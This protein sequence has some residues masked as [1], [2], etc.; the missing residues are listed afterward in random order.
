MILVALLAFALANRIN[1]EKEMRLSAQN[2]VLL[3]E[4]LARQS[5]TE[6]LKAQTD[7]NNQLEE[8]VEEIAKLS[9]Q[10]GLEMMEKKDPAHL[11]A[12]EKMRELM[13]DPAKMNQWF[14]SKRKEF[15]EALF[16]KF[17]NF[18]NGK[19]KNKK[20]IKGRKAK[21]NALFERRGFIGRA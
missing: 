17:I 19:S 21:R 2:K 6:L 5:Q 1:R 4:K 3:S 10:H 14:E 18:L 8:K 12:M 15:E 11:E 13:K 20:G 9:Q 16:T 7:A